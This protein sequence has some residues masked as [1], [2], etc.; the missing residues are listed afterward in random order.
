M[1]KR[2]LK[3]TVLFFAFAAFATSFTSCNKGYGCPS[4]FSV[5]K[6]AVQAAN[7][8]VSAAAATICE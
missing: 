6:V 3:S 8:V 2:M 7:V 4:N 5:D 1:K